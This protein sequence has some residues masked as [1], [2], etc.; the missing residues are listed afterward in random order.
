MKI[1]RYPTGFSVLPYEG[2]WEDQPH[3]IVI[4]F[5]IFLEAERYVATKELS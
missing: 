3:R 1:I 5:D 4:L 2:G